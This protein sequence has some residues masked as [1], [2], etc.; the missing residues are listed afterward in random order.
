MTSI[1]DIKK[2]ETQLGNLSDIEKILLIT[3]GSITNILDIIKGHVTIK[4]IKNDFCEVNGLA[5][6]LKLQKKD[7]LNYREVSIEHKRP[8]I[9]AI[10]L[11]PIKNL[12]KEIKN[13][14]LNAEI[15]IGRILKKHE[16]EARREIKY[17]GFEEINE[18]YKIMFNTKSKLLTRVYHII[19]QDEILMRIKETFPHNFF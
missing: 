11:I 4:T 1:T 16:I 8:L 12:D 14:L 18:D 13:D 7:V 9:H 17:I 15:P 3:D 10:S 5:D 2:I 6:E 19:H